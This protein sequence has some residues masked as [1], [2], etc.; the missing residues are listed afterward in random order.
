MYKINP[1]NAN[2]DYLSFDGDQSLIDVRRMYRVNNYIA[3]RLNNSSIIEIHQ[4][5]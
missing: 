5:E 3:E 4:I 2:F 1:R